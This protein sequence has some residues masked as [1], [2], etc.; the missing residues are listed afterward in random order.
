MKDDS[1]SGGK[2]MN[3]TDQRKT[4]ANGARRLVL[5][6]TDADYAVQVVRAF[7]ELDWEVYPARSGF[8]ARR[9]ARRLNADLVVLGAE[10]DVESGWLT[11]AKL[12]DESP[13]CQ[14]ILVATDPTYEGYEYTRFVGGVTLVDQDEGAQGL[15]DEVDSACEIHVMG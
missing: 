5:A 7:R 11:C 8:D 10:G 12:R 15:L 3:A 13:D 9:L 2:P 4:M 6:H 14:V 1:K